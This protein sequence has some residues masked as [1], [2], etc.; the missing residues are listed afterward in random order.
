MLSNVFQKSCH[1]LD[2]EIMCT[3]NTLLSFL[4]SERTI[5]LRYTCIVCLVSTYTYPIVYEDAEACRLL[6]RDVPQSARYLQTFRRDLLPLRNS[7]TIDAVDFSKSLV[8]R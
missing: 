5:M 4:C 8:A 1:L 7:L 6:S 3:Q 2:K